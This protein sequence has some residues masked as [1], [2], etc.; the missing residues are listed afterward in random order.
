MNSIPSSSKYVFKTFKVQLREFL[1]LYH[2]IM[3]KPSRVVLKISSIE[4]SRTFRLKAVIWDL[5]FLAFC[6]K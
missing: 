5:K 2:Y 4:K 1:P 6:Q 3:I